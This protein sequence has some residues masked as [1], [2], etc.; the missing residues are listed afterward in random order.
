ML[1]H[2][3]L[4][5][6]VCNQLPWYYFLLLLMCPGCAPS[7]TPQFLLH[8]TLCWTRYLISLYGIS[9]MRPKD[10]VTHSRV[11]PYLDRQLRRR[12]RPTRSSP[13]HSP[14]VCRPIEHRGRRYC[15]NIH[16]PVS[17]G[18]GER[19]GECETLI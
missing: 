14:A 12:R 8:E 15:V 5:W 4:Q 11:V 2:K 17:L 10:D 3:T 16:C 19:P 6:Q 18:D 1:I 7:H 13:V 9:L